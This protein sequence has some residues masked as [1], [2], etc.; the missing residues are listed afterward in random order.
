MASKVSWKR[1]VKLVVKA[2][3]AWKVPDNTKD[4]SSAPLKKKRKWASLLTHHLINKVNI[5]FGGLKTIYD[6]LGAYLVTKVVMYCNIFKPANLLLSRCMYHTIAQ[7]E[8]VYE[9]V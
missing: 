5:A 7:R 1:L 3:P 8:L 4:W 6:V 2:K 9:G